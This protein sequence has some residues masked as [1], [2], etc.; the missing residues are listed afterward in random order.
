MRDD[1]D[2]NLHEAVKKVVKSYIDRTR[3]HREN[4]E[5]AV[6]LWMVGEVLTMGSAKGTDR[7]PFEYYI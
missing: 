1:A 3:K 6:D 2:P 7:Q 4:D 5:R